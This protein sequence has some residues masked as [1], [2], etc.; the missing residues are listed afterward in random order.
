MITCPPCPVG[1]ASGSPGVSTIALLVY[2]PTDLLSAAAAASTV[3]ETL[4]ATTA[5]EGDPAARPA[6]PL[7]EAYGS[8]SLPCRKPAQPEAQVS[9]GISPARPAEI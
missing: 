8:P 2:S 3:A 9:P 7:L 6:F 5:A 4:D 1:S